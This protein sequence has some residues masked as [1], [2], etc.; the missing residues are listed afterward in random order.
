MSATPYNPYNWKFLL[1]TQ[2]WL[3]AI[4]IILSYF[5]QYYIEALAIYFVVF[6]GISFS[7][8]YKTNPMFRDRKLLAEVANSRV[9]YE[10]KDVTKIVQ[11]DAE[12]QREYMEAAKKNLSMMGIYVVYIIA[13]FIAYGY[14]VRFADSF[15]GTY[16]R[17]LVY[18]VYFEALY[19]VGYFMFRKI[20]RPT[21]MSVMAPTS[22]S[23]TEKGIYSKKGYSTFLHAKHLVDSKIDVNKEKHYVEIDSTSTKLPYKIRLYAPD[24]D[25]LMEYIERVKRLEL[26]RQSSSQQQKSEG[27]NT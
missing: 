17:L 23:V 12:L 10:E 3:V 19:L 2:V 13:L 18:L 16:G 20:L 1:L 26:K 15:P 21:M 6:L 22:Y 25:R 8:Q 9:I 4:S 24:V 27:A 11:A 14:L 7:I 5:P